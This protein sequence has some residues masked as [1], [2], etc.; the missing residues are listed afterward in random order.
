MNPIKILLVDDSKSARYA[1]RLQL[2]R[3]GAEVETAD[4]AESALERVKQSPPDAVFMDHTMPGMNGFE[5]LEILKADARTAHI[6]VVMCTSNEEPEFMAQARRKGALDILAKSASP[7]K[8]TALLARLQDAVGAAAAP[9]A[10]AAAT[11]AP[12]AVSSVTET[13]SEAAR[14]E[15]ERFLGEQLEQRLQTM[16]EPHLKTLA[17]RVATEVLAQTEKKL[18]ARLESETSRLQTHVAQAQSEQVRL[19]SDRIL[20]DALPKMVHRELED[21]V[22]RAVRQQ[23]E[24]EQTGIAQMVQ[25][26]ID[27]TVDRLPEDPTFLRRL[28]QRGAA[29]AASNAQETVRRHARE[30]AEETAAGHAGALAETM[31]KATTGTR[32]LSYVLAFGAA[33]IGIASAA[34]V[35]L[36]LQ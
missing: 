29:T 4:S 36:L 34:L 6:P 11:A 32:R 21:V 7:E 33:L 12:A 26:L 10:A 9:P 23:L 22:P 18:T 3:Q 24:H 13:A 28:Q 2:Q 31:R 16:L 8:L 14:R 5:A 1:L 25:E 15:T 20:N 27:T 19:A 35:Y 30:V 17:D